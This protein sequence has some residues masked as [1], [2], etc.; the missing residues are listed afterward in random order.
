MVCIRSM[1]RTLL[2]IFYCPEVVVLFV[3]L[4]RLGTHFLYTI[5]TVQYRIDTTHTHILLESRSSR[6][7]L[8]P[9][10]RLHPLDRG[11][12]N[13][14]TTHPTG[15]SRPRILLRHRLST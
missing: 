7:R 12:Q 5:Y 2:V 4:T 6:H 10:E 11:K 1:R 9:E 8:H 15:S 14:Q 13:L 3:T